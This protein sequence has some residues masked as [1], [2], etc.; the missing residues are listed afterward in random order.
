MAEEN[1]N[2]A[3]KRSAFFSLNISEQLISSFYSKNESQAGC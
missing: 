2:I 3:R 1:S